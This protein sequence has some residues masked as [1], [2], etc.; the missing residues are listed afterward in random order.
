ML[1]LT[2]MVLMI[3]CHAGEYGAE[4]VTS[5]PVR[6]KQRVLLAAG[7]LALVRWL[8]LDMALAVSLLVIIFC[9]VES[10]HLVQMKLLS[11]LHA[12]LSRDEDL[13]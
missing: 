12:D 6:W 10:M 4:L 9:I 8:P 7:E 13:I 3:C 1:R 11:T 5:T 2:L